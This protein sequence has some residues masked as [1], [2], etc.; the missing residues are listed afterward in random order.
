MHRRSFLRT[1]ALAPWAAV[2]AAG[3]FLQAC[4]DDSETTSTGAPAC[5]GEAPTAMDLHFHATCLTAAQLAAGNAV[6][7]TMTASGTG[8]THSL[9]LTSQNVMD[10][11]AGSPVTVTSAAG[12]GHTHT[13]SFN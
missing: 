9:S 3:A 10:I 13:V 4:G 6:T 1:L 8:H 12:G 7:V 11:A 2:A 5:D